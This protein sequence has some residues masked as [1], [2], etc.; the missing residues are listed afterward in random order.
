M[1]VLDEPV[2]SQPGKESDISLTRN[3]KLV[4]DSRS[5]FRSNELPASFAERAQVLL[6]ES[7]KAVL[8]A[9]ADAWFGIDQV[10]VPLSKTLT[11]KDLTL[12]VPKIAETAAMAAAIGFTADTLLPSTGIMGK[13]GRSALAAA[14][15]IPVA[16]QGY[17]IYAKISNASTLADL[18]QAGRQI[19]STVGNLAGNLPVGIAGYKAGVYAGDNYLVARAMSKYHINFPLSPEVVKGLSKGPGGFDIWMQM[20]KLPL[21]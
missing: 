21:D 20:S 18:Q 16:C 12:P 17:D 19:G 7:G 11:G 9:V 14:F 10:H 4:E 13:V 2:R 6:S 3:L 15:A 8:P 1:N 5:A